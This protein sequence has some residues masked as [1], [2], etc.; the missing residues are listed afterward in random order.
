VTG[1][2]RL[3]ERAREHGEFDTRSE[4]AGAD[5]AAYGTDTTR[6]SNHVVRLVYSR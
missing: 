1:L 3:E 6:G 5:S 2:T 4:V